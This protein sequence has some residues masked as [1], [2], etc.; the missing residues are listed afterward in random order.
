VKPYIFAHVYVSKVFNP[1]NRSVAIV[2]GIPIENK[3][4]E[5][6]LGVRWSPANEWKCPRRV[7]GSV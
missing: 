1:W 7:A 5:A 2:A 3:V 6:M 4:E